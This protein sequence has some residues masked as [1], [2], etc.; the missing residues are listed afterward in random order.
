MAAKNYLEYILNP[1]DLL[2]TKKVLLVNPTVI[3]ERELTAETKIST[4][5]YNVEKIESFTLKHV[6]DCYPFLNTTSNTWI[7]IDGLRKDDVEKI[8]AHFGIHQLITEDILSIGQ[9]PKMDELNG[10]VFCLLSMLYFNEKDSTVESFSLKYNIFKRQKTRPF[11]SSIFGRWPMLKIS[12][13]I[14]W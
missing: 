5:E 7:N 6:D 10:L 4:Y 12:S 13:V 11:N 2:R 14:S 8:C 3:P 1:L 9:R